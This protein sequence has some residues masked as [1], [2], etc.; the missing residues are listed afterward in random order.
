[1]AR[2]SSQCSIESRPSSP[3]APAALRP[4]RMPARRRRGT[5]RASSAGRAKARS[6]GLGN[7]PS[8]RTTVPRLAAQIMRRADMHRPARLRPV[9]AHPHR[10]AGREG[11]QLTAALQRG[12][13]LGLGHHALADQVVGDRADPAAVVAQPVVVGLGDRLDAAAQ[14][15]HRHRRASCRRIW[16]SAS[17]SLSK[18]VSACGSISTFSHMNLRNAAQVVMRAGSRRCP[19]GQILAA[20]R[21]PALSVA[22]RLAGSVPQNS[23]R[24]S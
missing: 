11:R 7:A 4:D 19:C 2:V 8:A 12:A 13:Q 1:M 15:V 23:S 20:R 24:L 9:V 10:R 16:R 14:L 17:T 22:D 18:S 5:A 3:V 21:C 6:S